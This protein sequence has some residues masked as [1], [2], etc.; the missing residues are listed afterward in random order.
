[1][2]RLF[3]LLNRIGLLAV[4]AAAIAVLTGAPALAE[5]PAATP[6]VKEAAKDTGKDTGKDAAKEPAKAPGK[7]DSKAAPCAGHEGHQGGHHGKADGKP[8]GDGEHKGGHPGEGKG[9][10]KPCCNKPTVAQAS[11]AATAGNK[12]R[13]TVRF[14]EAADGKVTVSIEIEGLTPGQQH[15]WHVHE[16]GDC[17]APDASSAGGHYNPDGH[18]HGLPEKNPKRH[19]GDFGNMLA[20]AQG[21]AKASLVVDNL[22]V[23]RK[24]GVLGRAVIVHAK[25]DDGNQPVGNAGPR[26]ACG[27][28]GVAKQ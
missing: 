6:P 18:D 23:A 7:D 2:L 26:L 16:F 15:A 9:D 24:S 21:K 8:C 5:K 4:P 19:A 11:L 25:A 10:G 3:S 17:S 27:V 13:G 22:S 28:I 14:T 20:D 1:M 12:T